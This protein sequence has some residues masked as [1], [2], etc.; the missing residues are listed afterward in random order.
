MNIYVWQVTKVRAVSINRDHSRDFDFQ[1][2][3]WKVHHNRLKVRL[4]NC[5]DWESFTGTCRMSTTLGGAGNVDDNVLDFPGGTY[6]AV[7]LRS[8]DFISQTWAI[9]WLDSR[10]PHSLDV[11]VIGK[12]SDGIGRFYA[13]DMFDN[14]PV[15]VRF[16]WSQTDTETPHWEQAMSTD[17]G[18]TWETNWTMSFERVA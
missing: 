8:F 1:I 7:T 5:E 11:P 10:S 18:N 2:G 9:W 17:G 13:D 6:R 12:F 16:I 14:I 15:R 3:S 4:A